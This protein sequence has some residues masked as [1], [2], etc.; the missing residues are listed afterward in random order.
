[1]GVRRAREPVERLPAATGDGSLAVELLAPAISS[2]PLFASP[3][4][5]DARAAAASFLPHL[6]FLDGDSRG[7]VLLDDHAAQ[8]RGDVVFR[9]DG[10]WNARPRKRAAPASSA[11]AD[12]R[13]SRRP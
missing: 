9:A 2:P 1:M 11:S 8:I 10:C 4:M 5:R 3:S 7:Y 6:K 12:R 13:A